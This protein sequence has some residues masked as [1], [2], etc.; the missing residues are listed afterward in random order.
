MTRRRR[1]RALEYEHLYHLMAE[2]GQPYGLSAEEVFEARPFLALTP[3]QQRQQFAEFKASPYLSEE[4]RRII[5]AG[6][7][8]FFGAG[9]DA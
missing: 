5:E 2:A 3:A 8:D 4:E 1:L 7:R 9:G 6:E